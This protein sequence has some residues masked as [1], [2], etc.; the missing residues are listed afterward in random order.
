MRS[1]HYKQYSIP[2][3]CVTLNGTWE[4]G[5]SRKYTTVADIPGRT[6]DPSPV[7]AGRLWYRREIVLPEGDWKYAT[8]ELKGARFAP[9]VFVDGEPVSRQNGGMAPTFHLLSYPAVKPGHIVLLEIALSS[10]HDLTPADASLIPAADRR[11]SDPAACLWDDI[12]LH[13]HN[14]IFPTGKPFRRAPTK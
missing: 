2:G 10:L 1:T 8:L 14:I 7:Y 3:F 13:L 11:R 12:V 5:F 4:M 9:E 6:I